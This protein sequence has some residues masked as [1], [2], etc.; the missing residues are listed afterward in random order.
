[1]TTAPIIRTQDVCATVRKR[2]RLKSARDHFVLFPDGP[3]HMAQWTSDNLSESNWLR[4]CN[5]GGWSGKVSFDEMVRKAIDGDLAPVAEAD[6]LLENFTD[7]TFPTRGH[8]TRMDVVGSLPNIPAYLAGHPLNMRCKRRVTHDS[9]PL[10]IVA[11][12]TTSAGISSR[13]MQR[14]G[15][16]ILAFVQAIATRRP[17]ELWV[18]AGLGAGP[19]EASNGIWAFC[20]IETAPLD[21]AHAAPAMA[22]SMFTRGIAYGAAEA[23]THCHGGWPYNDYGTSQ[24]CFGDIV[25]GMLPHIDEFVAIPGIASDDELV[26][27]PVAWIKRALQKYL[28]NG[29]EMEQAS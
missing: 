19:R 11:D 22:Y 17:I 5:E 14:R 9:A 1:M 27:N 13:A 29:N 24:T 7:E 3:G 23:Y 12:G 18:G 10:A 4:R 21:L 25:R 16:A 15:M 28:G 6:K 26:S 2:L 8:Q 20:K